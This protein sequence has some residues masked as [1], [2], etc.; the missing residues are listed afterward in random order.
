MLL[1]LLKLKSCGTHL[2][3]MEYKGTAGAGKESHILATPPTVL[4]PVPSQGTATEKRDKT[5]TGPLSTAAHTQQC[6][7]AADLKLIP[8]SFW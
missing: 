7:H 2:R 8:M 5:G 4:P 3:W 1:C 6:R